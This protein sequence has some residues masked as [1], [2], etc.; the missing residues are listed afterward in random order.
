MHGTKGAARITEDGVL[1]P[2]LPGNSVVITA[3]SKQD[4]SKYIT[5]QIKIKAYEVGNDNFIKIAGPTNPMGFIRYEKNKEAYFDVIGEPYG[6]TSIL[7]NIE[8]L[9]FKGTGIFS[10]ITPEN[11]DQYIQIL[12][13]EPLS[14]SGNNEFNT[15]LNNYGFRVKFMPKEVCTMDVVLMDG[16]PNAGT[17]LG[18]IEIYGSRT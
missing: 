2:Q 12:D 13:Y 11:S 9:G 6:S 16:A 1:Y 18:N 3:K 17:T 4:P 14:S 15:S 7:N 5:S 8:Y 10:N